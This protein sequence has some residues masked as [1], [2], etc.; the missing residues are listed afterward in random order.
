MVMPL[1]RARPKFG[2]CPALHT[3]YR[4]RQPQV[5]LALQIMTTE[6][7]RGPRPRPWKGVNNYSDESTPPPRS[8]SDIDPSHHPLLLWCV[9]CWQFVH[10][11]LVELTKGAN[12]M[13]DVVLFD[14]RIRRGTELIPTEYHPTPI[15]E[16]AKLVE[17]EGIRRELSTHPYLYDS[18]WSKRVSTAAKKAVKQHKGAPGLLC[19]IT[20]GDHADHAPEG[21]VPAANFFMS[22]ATYFVRDLKI[23][24]EQNLTGATPAALEGLSEPGPEPAPAAAPAAAPRKQ[25]TKEELEARRAKIRAD[26]EAAKRARD[27]AKAAAAAAAAPPESEPEPEPQTSTPA[28]AEQAT[29][30]QEE[31]ADAPAAQPEPK[32]QASTPGP[33]SADALEQL[34]AFNNR[35]AL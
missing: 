27:E 22:V 2:D 10:P 30:A 33:G 26:V 19:L 14:L 31:E 16:A 9:N 3:R 18:G 6:P 29:L 5:A 25:L 23:I 35:L 4:E 15:M 34:L 28:E 1:S 12:V 7:W 13:S 8:G 32:P 20:Y 24:A 11:R 21:A 17:L